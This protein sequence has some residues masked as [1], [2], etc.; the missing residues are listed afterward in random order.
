MCQRRVARDLSLQAEAPQKRSCILFLDCFAL[1]FKMVQKVRERRDRGAGKRLAVGRYREIF[2][3]V[4]REITNLEEGVSSDR[5]FG[6]M[7][8]PHDEFGDCRFAMAV[9]RKLTSVPAL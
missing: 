3:R 6:R 8:L 1:L 9:L 7:K 2:N 4:L 5:A